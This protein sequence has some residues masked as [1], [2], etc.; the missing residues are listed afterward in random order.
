MGDKD[1]QLARPAKY[2]LYVRARPGLILRDERVR[3]LKRKLYVECPWLTVADDP[4]ARRFC[5]LQVLIEQVYA[6]IRTTGVLNPAGDVKIAVDS[7]RK[8]TL[9][10]ATIA[11]ALGLTPASRTALKL[12][13][14]VEFDLA[15]VY[16]AVPDEV[17]K[18]AV[19]IG[20][21]RAAERAAAAAKAKDVETI[22]DG[23]EVED[24]GEPSKG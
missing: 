14:N 17:I 16:A 22:Q 13:R 23:Q 2:G 1:N 20:E 3:R 8:L 12:G 4:M 5:E 15:A 18:N 19:E 7:H 11:N 10:Q 24:G 6:F 21:S 9:A